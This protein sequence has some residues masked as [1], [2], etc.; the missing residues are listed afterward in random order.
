MLRIK[1]DIV[2]FDQCYRQPFWRFERNG[3]SETTILEY[4]QTLLAKY[5][6]TES[7]PIVYLQD[8]V[9][10]HNESPEILRD[11]DL[12][13]LV[14]ARRGIAITHQF[15]EPQ[16]VAAYPEICQV[17]SY[18]EGEATA[19]I[20]NN[21]AIVQN[22][23][24]PAALPNQTAA[25]LYDHADVMECEANATASLSEPSQNDLAVSLEEG[26][27]R[28]TPRTIARKRRKR[29]PR[30]RVRTK[31][32]PFEARGD[33]TTPPE[34]FSTLQSSVTASGEDSIALH[35]STPYPAK[36][37][38]YTAPASTSKIKIG[39]HRDDGVA[40]S[41]ML[42]LVDAI[43]VDT[44]DSPSASTLESEPRKRS[45]CK[46]TQEILDAGLANEDAVSVS[47]PLNS[48]RLPSPSSDA[49]KESSLRSVSTKSKP[50]MKMSSRKLAKRSYGIGD[51]L[52]ILKN[53]GG[54]SSMD[55]S[56]EDVCAP[57]RGSGS[58]HADHQGRK[59]M[60]AR[61][62][63]QEEEQPSGDKLAS[64]DCYV[65]EI[66]PKGCEDACAPPRRSGS[67]NAD[68]QGRKLIKARE[69]QQEEEQ[70]SG[71]KLASDDCYVEEIP[72]EIPPKVV[73]K[74][75]REDEAECGEVRLEDLQPG[76]RFKTGVTLFSDAKLCACF[77]DDVT[78]AV[79]HINLPK[80]QLYVQLEEGSLP[81]E[82][83]GTTF[84][85]DW[86]LL[87][88]VQLLSPP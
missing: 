35:Q 74:S 51:L 34:P 41:P 39:D 29:G 25:P 5:G 52:Q 4:A 85:V 27:G 38:T 62:D 11:G 79:E 44:C 61:E 87:V 82:Y 7:Y 65:E 55:Q 83:Q 33:S 88:D 53:N 18:V 28:A 67:E 10:P 81:A 59:L 2:A 20:V 12:L 31:R 56:C 77:F 15:T 69:D 78:L 9:V 80:R 8:A 75:P 54:N 23:V 60:K 6:I 71:D 86:P 72:E 40:S 21:M 14:P 17:P 49:N 1:L 16:A 73:A 37:V 63:Q 84:R 50:P 13:R 43:D 47:E 32:A 24:T 48:R 46:E 30:R 42:R 26:S 57:P 45:K 76:S 36:T 58:E 68:H 19:G 3:I 70:P 66:L 22:S 64:T